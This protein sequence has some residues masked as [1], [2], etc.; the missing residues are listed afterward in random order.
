MYLEVIV[1][2][3]LILKWEG[4][5]KMTKGE[6]KHMKIKVDAA[7]GAYE[8]KDDEEKEPGTVDLTELEGIYQSKGFKHVG[9]ILHA[10]SSPG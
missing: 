2:T 4:V 6:S 5:Y 9:V 10:E 8:V 1:N 7:T 3:H